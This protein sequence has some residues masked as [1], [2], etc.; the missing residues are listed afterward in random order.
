MYGEDK[1]RL[2]NKKRAQ[3]KAADEI[4]KLSQEMDGLN[5]ELNGIENDLKSLCIQKRNQY[6]KHRMEVDYSDGLREFEQELCEEEDDM[7]IPTSRKH[8]PTQSNG[9]AIFCVCS[10]AFQILRHR[11]L[12]S[13]PQGFLH[14]RDTQMPQ[15]LQHCKDYTFP[16]R[17]R[18]ARTAL[19]DID[20][21]RS[22]MRGWADNTTPDK[23]ITM[24]QKRMLKECFK[25]HLEGFQKVCLLPLPL[26]IVRQ[27]SLPYLLIV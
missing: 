23:Q 8:D 11:S 18:L 20:R 21:L 5:I 15:M 14:V 19:E 17:E 13:L 22:R 2:N 24:V 7:S 6:V 26:R 1:K 4:E 25:E 27:E 10:K 16:A 9:V 3:R 12:E